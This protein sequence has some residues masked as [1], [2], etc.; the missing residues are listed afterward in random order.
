MNEIGDDERG[1]AINHVTTK[2]LSQNVVCNRT[3]PFVSSEI[4]SAVVW[5]DRV[6]Q[7]VGLTLVIPADRAVE[8]IWNWNLEFRR[9]LKLE[10]NYI[11]ARC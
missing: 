5:K 1:E 7:E 10:W 2:F 3:K 4:L 6:A 11:P 9:I 8:W